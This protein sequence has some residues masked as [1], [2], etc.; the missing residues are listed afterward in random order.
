M[1]RR[2][3]PKRP[4]PRTRDFAWGM[5]C[6]HRMHG[7]YNRWPPRSTMPRSFGPP[8]NAG[9]RIVQEALTFD[10]VL[11]VPAYSDVLPRE[12]DLSTRLTRGIRPQPP[13]RLRRDGHGHRGPPRDHDRAGRRHR[14]HPQEHDRRRPGARGRARQE[15][16]ERRHQG[17]D[18][19]AAR[20]RRSARSSRSR[21]PR[22]S[23]ACRSPPTATRSSASSRTATSASRSSS[24]CRCRRS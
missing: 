10:D 11:L 19:R 12:V 4:A 20:T 2:A 13:V 17:P 1:S 24:T 23:R 7:T 3:S 6:E 14:H 9:M 18:H 22:A 5:L 8:R 15:A 21:A 16:R